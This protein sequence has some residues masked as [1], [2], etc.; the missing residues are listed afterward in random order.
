[1][2]G[3]PASPLHIAAHKSFQGEHVS[4]HSFTL[5]HSDT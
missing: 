4:H 3:D 2:T 5:S 1:M